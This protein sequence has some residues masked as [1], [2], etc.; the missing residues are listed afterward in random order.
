[1]IKYLAGNQ[2]AVQL[3]AN[4]SSAAAAVNNRKERMD[5]SLLVL[6]RFG[7]HMP[8][9]PTPGGNSSAAWGD[10]LD[11]E[12]VEVAELRRGGVVGLFEP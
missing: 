3:S 6:V 1:M 9:Y 12:A 4:A 7:N 5:S 11:Q 2:T 10:D 8:A